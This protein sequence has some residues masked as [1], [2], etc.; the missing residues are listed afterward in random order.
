VF[1]LKW[2]HN[3]IEKCLLEHIKRHKYDMKLNSV[4]DRFLIDLYFLF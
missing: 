4:Y 2:I 1:Y 3:L